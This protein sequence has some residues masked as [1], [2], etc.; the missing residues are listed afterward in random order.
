MLLLA[1]FGRSAAKTILVDENNVKLIIFCGNKKQF[2]TSK[3]KTWL[4]GTN[5]RLP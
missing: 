2:K 3:G 1:P 4:R 5:S